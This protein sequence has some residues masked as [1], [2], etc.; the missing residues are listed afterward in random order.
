MNLFLM[1]STTEELAKKTQRRDLIR[2]VD[3]YEHRLDKYNEFVIV[4]RG[5]HKYDLLFFPLLI[6]V[7]P[8]RTST[9]GLARLGLLLVL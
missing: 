8:V 3:P 1:K 2:G 4:L 9:N 5:Q 6:S 7:Q